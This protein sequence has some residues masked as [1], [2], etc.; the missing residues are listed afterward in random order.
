MAQRKRAADDRLAARELLK[1]LLPCQI[2]TAEQ[3]GAMMGMS[4]ARVDQITT[5]A[6]LRVRAAVLA[7]EKEDL[8]ASKDDLL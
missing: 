5:Q 7:L 8:T 1:A 3:V 6:L 2:R 4:R